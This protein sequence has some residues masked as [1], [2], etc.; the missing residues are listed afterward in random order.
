[1]LIVMLGVHD[2]PAVSPAKPL[3]GFAEAA[4]RYPDAPAARARCAELASQLR[5]AAL[6]GDA[7]RVSR[8]LSDL[9]RL[10]GLSKGE[11]IAAEPAGE[12]QKVRRPKQPGDTPYAPVRPDE[13]ALRCGTAASLPAGRVKSSPNRGDRIRGSPSLS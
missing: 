11:R 6:E 12:A 5:A 7:A 10:Q 13:S 8:L 3:S 2:R 1:M 9:L 4:P